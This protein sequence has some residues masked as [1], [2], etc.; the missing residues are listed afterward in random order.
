M[1]A[2][3]FG[4]RPGEKYGLEGEREGDARTQLHLLRVC[5]GGAVDSIVTSFMESRWHT[6]DGGNDCFQHGDQLHDQHQSSALQWRNRCVVPH[7]TVGVLFPS[8]CK[9]GHGHRCDG[10]VVQRTLAWHE[11]R[12][13]KFL[14]TSTEGLYKN[15]IADIIGDCDDT[16]DRRY[17]FNF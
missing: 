12:P 7:T 5:D 4:S 10:V 11:D 15:S 16:C 17:T 2:S 8:V 6:V 13:G 1:G 14:H 9:C 3:L